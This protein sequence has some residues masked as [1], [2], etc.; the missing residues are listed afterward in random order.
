M[1]STKRAPDP[2]ARSFLLFRCATRRTAIALVLL[3]V[4][5]S[6]SEEPS[7]GAPDA[8][9]GA[10][11]PPPRD[12]GGAP[13][14]D[15]S[16]DAT[17]DAARLTVDCKVT[18]C[19]RDLSASWSESFCALLDDGRVACWGRNQDGELGRDAGPWSATAQPV[20]GVADAIALDRTCAVVADGGVLCWGPAAA[21]ETRT[22]GTVHIPLPPARSVRSE[23]NLGCA[24]V[25]D[26]SVACW[27]LRGADGVLDFADAGA[28]GD[29]VP[30][31]I[32]PLDGAV[33]ELAIAHGHRAPCAYC[34][35]AP[36]NAV[37][38][39]HTDGRVA[40]WG[41]APLV[42]RATS[43][44]P[45]PEP[46][47][48]PVEHGDHLAGGFGACALARGALLC[49]G[50]RHEDL[51]EP[52]LIP[53]LP[54]A[55][56]A[57][58]GDYRSGGGANRFGRGCAASVSGTVHCWGLNDFGQAGDGTT[59]LR[60]EPAKVDGLPEPVVRVEVTRGTSCALGV[61]GRIHCWG[62]DAF[63]Q[64]GQK[65]PFTKDHAPLP[66]ELP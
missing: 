38:A 46:A 24:V 33:D 36:V 20:D 29:F 42:G 43:R 5:A 45:D 48:I 55:S 31:T 6:C 60:S 2:H 14:N 34:P 57:A 54:S 32:V 59:A 62:D 52:Q 16:R 58:L 17:Y 10:S 18:P 51:G 11:P 22:G 12:D 61:S 21:R 1:F 27:G 49:W 64:R 35:V 23:E 39:R 26:G 41:L 53:G 50:H 44:L 4:P 28:P 63:G 47:R 15:A 40:S 9:D 7:V 37:I 65:T 66:V 3:A 56:Q 30:P 8:P 13:V 19:A 25:N